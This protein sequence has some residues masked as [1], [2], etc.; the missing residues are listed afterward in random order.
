MY[1]PAFGSVA[2]VTCE[3]FS[4]SQGLVTTLQL[5]LRRRQED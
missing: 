3:E 5:L 1:L 4:G 2:V